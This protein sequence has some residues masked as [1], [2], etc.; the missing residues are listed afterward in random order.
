MPRT[1]IHPSK[2]INPESHLG[3]ELKN[4]FVL[5]LSVLA[6]VFFWSPAVLADP[7]SSEILSTPDLIK[8]LQSGGHIIY[9]RHGPTNL[10]QKDVD[11]DNF[12]DCS[13]QRNLSAEGRDLAK[14]IGHAI[15]ELRIPV[16]SVSSSPYCRC[17]DTARL[18]FGQFHIEP[19]LR[20]SISADKQESKQLGERLYSMM[21]NS[22]VST[23]NVV[24]V[25]HT[26]NL[27]DGL[28][29]WPKP[30]AVFV[31]FQKRENRLVY[32]GMITPDAWPKR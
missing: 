16:G 6:P 23:K 26:S 11:R 4:L 17:K 31:V 32:K 7:V 22:E 2:I 20:F 14:H 30:E 19:D 8:A 21:L 29:V 18:V 13:S 15:K 24:F 12:E 27:E 3:I 9:M 5:L 10:S 28:G 1:R 25:G